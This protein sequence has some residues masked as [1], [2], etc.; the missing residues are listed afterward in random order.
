MFKKNCCL[1]IFSASVFFIFSISGCATVFN[2]LEEPNKHIS[3]LAGLP[4]IDAS[5]DNKL[6]SLVIDIER[7][8]P[9]TPIDLVTKID[10]GEILSDAFADKRD[11]SLRISYVNSTID[12]F[13]LGGGEVVK[14]IYILTVSVNDNKNIYFMKG[15]G[16][17]SAYA[18]SPLAAKAAAENAVLDLYHQVNY[19]I[20]NQ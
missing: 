3:P 9:F 6:S 13:R 14:G 2:K 15:F 8:Y 18:S 10:F 11:S 4:K 12:I 20:K 7:F 17:S 1:S 16:S 19:L 5:I